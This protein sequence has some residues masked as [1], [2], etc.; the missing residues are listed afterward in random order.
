[1]TAHW[2]KPCADGIAGKTTNA[3]VTIRPKKS[4]GQHFLREPRYATRLV[5]AL[6]GDV[7]SIVEVGPG[8]GMLTQ[9]LVPLAEQLVLVEKDRELAALM[10]EKWSGESHVRVVEGDFLRLSPEDFFDRGE[11]VVAG[12]FPY[13]ISSQIVFRVLDAHARVPEMVGMFQLEMARRIASGPGSKEYGIISVMTAA[14][15]TAELLFNVPP[16]AFQPPPKVTSAVIRLRRKADVV[17]PCEDR[18]L[19]TIVRAAFGQRRKMLRNSLRALLPDTMLSDPLFQRRPEQLSLEE[20]IDI[21][22]RYEHIVRN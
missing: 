19:S 2:I 21:A 5:E 14:Y 18:S 22:S 7:R 6:S 10:R 16:G 12:N 20:F 1:M 17:L 11:F 3:P 8:P 9:Y 4:L 13:N 15:Y